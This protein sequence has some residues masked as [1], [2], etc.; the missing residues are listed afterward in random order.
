L[1]G[2]P[3]LGDNVGAESASPE[4][5]TATPDPVASRRSRMKPELRAGMILEAA[6]KY[7]AEH[8]FEAQLKQLA[9]RIGVSEGLIF[10]YFGTK[11]NLVEAVYQ[12]VF[13]ERWSRDWE[14]GLRERSQ[15]LRQRLETF[16]RSYLEAVDE[17]RWIR[18]SVY[19]GL[20]GHD[21]IRRYIDTHVDQLLKII[22]QELYA[23]RGLREPVEV[24]ALDLEL[25]WHLHSTFIYFLIRKHVHRTPTTTD[26]AAMVERIV[27]NFLSGFRPAE[28][29]PRPGAVGPHRRNPKARSGE[30]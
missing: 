7:F 14:R 19:A 25:A 22:V 21:I 8:G 2:L 15:P 9:Q 16:Y 1:D 10:R 13:L 26:R 4:A 28:A 20:A 23:E 11:Q 3:P 5:K 27:E 30:G 18:V 17:P 12:R 6:T 24:D 29:Q